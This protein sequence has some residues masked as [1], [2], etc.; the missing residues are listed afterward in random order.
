[1]AEK[2]KGIECTYI[3]ITEELYN[4]ETLE[5]FDTLFQE[6]AVY[7]SIEIDKDNIEYTLDKEQVDR[8]NEI[9]GKIIIDKPSEAPNLIISNSKIAQLIRDHNIVLKNRINIHKYFANEIDDSQKKITKYTVIENELVYP[10]GIQSISNGD[11]PIIFCTATFE[12][13]N[14]V[15]GYLSYRINAE[16]RSIYISF[17]ET[18]PKLRGQHIC[19]GLIKFLTS[20]KKYSDINDYSLLN[21]GGIAACKCYSSAFKAAG[22][23]YTTNLNESAD[24]ECPSL[25]AEIEQHNESSY[26]MYFTRNKKTQNGGNKKTKKNNNRLK[27]RKFTPFR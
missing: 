7:E 19:N 2:K 5:E 24:Q 10:E 25:I 26:N 17:V 27:S 6:S 18:H 8:I 14:I 9:A 23:S 3:L 12:G 15:A 16:P 11:L 20:I 4:E 13:K 1:M 22:F 21:V